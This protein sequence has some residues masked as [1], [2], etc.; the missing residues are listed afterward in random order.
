[1]R[2]QY[3]EVRTYVYFV[4]LHCGLQ[5]TVKGLTGIVQFDINGVRMAVS[6]DVILHNHTKSTKIGR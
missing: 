1:M 3:L 5:A 6:L 4:Q 2:S